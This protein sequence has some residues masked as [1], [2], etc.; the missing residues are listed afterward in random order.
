PVV[1]VA[2]MGKMFNTMDVKS[3][4]LLH[5]DLG[6]GPMAVEPEL[7]VRYPSL[8]ALGIRQQMRR[9]M[10]AEEM[11]VLYVALT[12]AREKLV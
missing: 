3:P 6:F 1:F 7:Q 12:R 10:L 4:F 8:A 5:K 11:R 9:E 2:G